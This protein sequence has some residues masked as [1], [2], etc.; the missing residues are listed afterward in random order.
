MKA[1]DRRL[2]FSRLVQ[3]HVG[4]P[5]PC[6]QEMNASDAQGFGDPEALK[7]F[8]KYFG[9]STIDANT[10]V[11]AF[12]LVPIP[13][14]VEKRGEAFFYLAPNLKVACS[15]ECRDRYQHFW[16]YHPDRVK[17]IDFLVTLQAGG[18]GKKKVKIV[19]GRIR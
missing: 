16:E 5:C 1:L 4:K 15:V 10:A 14:G 19:G 13:R 3:E 2:M 18:E 12:R 8:Q 9:T 7:L 11:V 17:F 6:C